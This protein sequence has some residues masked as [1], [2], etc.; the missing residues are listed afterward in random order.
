MLGAATF[1]A[2]NVEHH[3]IGALAIREFG[4]KANIG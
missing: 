4:G 3:L 2:A 1:A